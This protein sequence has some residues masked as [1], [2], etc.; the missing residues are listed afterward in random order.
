MFMGQP[1]IGK[2][3]SFILYSILINH[4][5]SYYMT[6]NGIEMVVIIDQINKLASMHRTYNNVIRGLKQDKKT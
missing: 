5:T 6:R 1:G 2:T 3:A 4:V